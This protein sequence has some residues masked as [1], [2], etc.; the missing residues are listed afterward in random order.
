[1]RH[2]ERHSDYDRTVSLESELRDLME[3]VAAADI[4]LAERL[5]AATRFDP[6]AQVDGVSKGVLTT[7]D[8]LRI[9]GRLEGL[10]EAVLELGRQIDTLK[11]QGAG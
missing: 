6:D 4:D 8:L 10:R 7:A 9:R 11:S 2:D 3:N 5:A 1:M